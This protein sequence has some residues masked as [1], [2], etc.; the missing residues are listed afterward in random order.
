MVGIGSFVCIIKTWKA[1]KESGGNSDSQL[2][3]RKSDKLEGTN[4]LESVL[5]GEDLN[6]K[7]E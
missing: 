5:V 2:C 3:G 7:G 4:I 6:L 1:P